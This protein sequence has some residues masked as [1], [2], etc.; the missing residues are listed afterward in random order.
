MPA[1][2][3]DNMSDLSSDVDG[4]FDKA[5]SQVRIIVWRGCDGEGEAGLTV[6]HQKSCLSPLI[7]LS[8]Q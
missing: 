6:Y 5:A 3:E 1:D 2:D 7:Y 8:T 4:D